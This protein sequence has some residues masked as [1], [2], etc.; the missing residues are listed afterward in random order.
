MRRRGQLAVG[1]LRRVDVRRRRPDVQHAG[2]G[3]R[4]EHVRPEVVSGPG[5]QL[6]PQQQRLRRPAHGLRE[7]SLRPDVRRRGLQ[8]VRRPQPRARWRSALH[9]QDVRGLPGRHLRPAGRRVQRPH[10]RLRLVH[11]S[12][13]L[14]RRRPVALRRQPDED[15]RRR[16]ALHPDHLRRARVHLWTGER[17]LRRDHRSVWLVHG[18]AVL[19]RRR[20]QRV[21][22]QHRPCA[23]RRCARHLHAEVV[24]RARRDVRRPGRR[25]RGHDGFVRHVRQPAVLRRRRPQRVRRQQRPGVRRRH[26]LRAEDLRELSGDVRPRRATAAAG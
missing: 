5:L 26:R 11:G 17:R 8:Q 16:G 4:P 25:L 23:R 1:R 10:G 7:L 15:G 20:R 22:R 12:A 24:R 3:Q 14:R 18:S 2:L 9:A 6:R 21:R 13:I 19:R